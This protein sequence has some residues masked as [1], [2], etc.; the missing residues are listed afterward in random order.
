MQF[1]YKSNSLSFEIISRGICFALILYY[2]TL[3]LGWFH[4]S[5]WYL[6]IFIYFVPS[7]FLRYFNYK[8]A[9]AFSAVLFFSIYSIFIFSR[10]GILEPMMIPYKFSIML[11]S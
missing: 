11:F 2:A 10:I 6:T 5:Y 1:K 7:Y 9:A 4:R 8:R 3:R